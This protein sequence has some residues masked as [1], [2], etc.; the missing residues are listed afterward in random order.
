MRGLHH[1]LRKFLAYPFFYPFLNRGYSFV[2]VC[3]VGLSFIFIIWRYRSKI[4]WT[5]FC[6]CLLYAV[7]VVLSL[8][9]APLAIL[10]PFMVGPRYFF[11]PY[12][13]LYWLTI[14]LFFQVGH[15]EKSFLT[16]LLL[17]GLYSSLVNYSRT[18]DPMSWRGY[19]DKG[20]N[21]RSS[22][23]IPIH[24]DGVATRAWPLTIT[25]AECSRLYQESLFK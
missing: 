16:M 7:S 5:I 21:S 20:L 17:F 23:S 11:Y 18:S 6:C 24:Y 13:F 19:I 2:L 9:R 1:I 10:D 3:A 4:N 15:S 14:N 8:A 25:P 22:F 12:I